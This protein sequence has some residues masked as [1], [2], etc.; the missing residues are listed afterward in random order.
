[1]SSNRTTSLS[2]VWTTDTGSGR[3]CELENFAVL[4][5]NWESLLPPSGGSG[6]LSDDGCEQAE[7][8]RRIPNCRTQIQNLKPK[9]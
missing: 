9:T 8:V 4:P 2:I 7:R 5:H 6:V 1:M 3:D